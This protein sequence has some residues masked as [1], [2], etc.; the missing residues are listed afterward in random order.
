[1]EGVLAEMG[2]MVS[3]LPGPRGAL[4]RDLFITM[5]RDMGFERM[6]R[7]ADA[8]A[9]RGDLR[10]RLHRIACPALMLW[11]EHDQFVAAPDG[12]ALSAAISGARYVEIAGCGHF[13]TLEAPAE[14]IAALRHW[15]VDSK[16]T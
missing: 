5:G 8:L 10:P 15:L 4:A 6:A 16:L 9:A 1:M 3:H 2:A 11:G 14:A 13:P 7:Q 12:L